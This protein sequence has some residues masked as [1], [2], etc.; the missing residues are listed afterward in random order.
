MLI[1]VIIYKLIIIVKDLYLFIN[2]Y[3]LYQ[4]KLK[5]KLIYLLI[6]E[7]KML[8]FQTKL[9]KKILKDFKSKFGLEKQR[10]QYKLLRRKIK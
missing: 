3:K 9:E 5:I 8:N 7:G 6:C 10:S 1:N 4:N 2:K